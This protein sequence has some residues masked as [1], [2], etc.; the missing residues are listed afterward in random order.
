MLPVGEP[1]WSLAKSKTT[2]APAAGPRM[3][4]YPLR[5]QRGLS[6]VLTI[7]KEIRQTICRNCRQNNSEIITIEM[8]KE[9]YLIRAKCVVF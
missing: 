6:S 5:N 4:C 3:M 7:T 8:L 1:K 9:A 2:Q